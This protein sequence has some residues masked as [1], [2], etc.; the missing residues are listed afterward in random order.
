MGTL[1]PKRALSNG[2]IVGPIWSSVVTTPVGDVSVTATVGVMVW[3]VWLISVPSVRASALQPVAVLTEQS[4]SD[5][6]PTSAHSAW[7]IGSRYTGRVIPPQFHQPSRRLGLRVLE[8]RTTRS[9]SSPGGLR[10]GA[11]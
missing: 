6:T 11:G 4:V 2:L 8:T 3:S 5:S 9:L 10:F 1:K 7:P